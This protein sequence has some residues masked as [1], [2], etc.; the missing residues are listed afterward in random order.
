MFIT[1][2]RDWI[3]SKDR[4]LSSYSYI[5]Q[6]QHIVSKHQ[7]KPQRNVS[8]IKENHSAFIKHQKDLAIHTH[9][10]IL[11]LLHCG[12]L[13]SLA[14]LAA[15]PHCGI[16]FPER[17]RWLY[18]YDGGISPRKR[19][20]ISWRDIPKNARRLATRHLQKYTALRPYISALFLSILFQAH[21]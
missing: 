17:K 5:D 3:V 13:W 10:G 20:F 2:Q 14:R 9:C 21:P 15:D 11:D 6:H 8:N 16:S 4:A 19:W 1:S 12:C 18:M 7:K